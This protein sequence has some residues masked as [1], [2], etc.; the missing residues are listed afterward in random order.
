[1][2]NK[3]EKFH[4]ASC[5]CKFKMIRNTK[6]EMLELFINNPVYKCSKC[7]N[8]LKYYSYMTNDEIH[9]EFDDINKT[10]IKDEK[11]IKNI[12]K[13]KNLEDKKTIEYYVKKNI[14]YE[15][16][17]PIFNGNKVSNG[18]ILA[19]IKYLISIKND[20]RLAYVFSYYMYET[21]YYCWKYIP[22][23]EKQYLI[24]K[25]KEFKEL[26]V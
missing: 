19:S 8:N 11:N 5:D 26:E 4:V 13:K 12:N 9:N 14:L 22:K 24:E 6:K 2:E 3:I 20:E 17:T 16:G 7:K 18:P 23:K 10:K 25:F 21:K 15:D 1:M